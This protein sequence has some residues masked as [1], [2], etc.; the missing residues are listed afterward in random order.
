MP[1][2]IEK[3]RAWRYEVK[4]ISGF[5]GPVYLLDGGLPENS[6]WDRKLTHHLYGG[7]AWYRLCQVLRAY[8]E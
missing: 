2:R 4:G 7:D 6:E 5:A 1:R 3:V 8:F